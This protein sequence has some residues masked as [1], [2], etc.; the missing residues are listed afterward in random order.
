[1]SERHEAGQTSGGV[2]RPPV[3]FGKYIKASCL[4]TRRFAARKTFRVFDCPYHRVFV[5]EKMA[6]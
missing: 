2:R 3:D 1:M 6:W 5:L 4:T